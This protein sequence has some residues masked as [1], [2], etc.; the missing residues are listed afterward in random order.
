[1]K[2]IVSF[3]LITALGLVGCRGEELS[4]RR[5]KQTQETETTDETVSK[6]KAKTQTEESRTVAQDDIDPQM[7]QM[8]LRAAESPNQEKYAS[9]KVEKANVDSEPTDDQLA[10]LI[11]M[12][13][14]EF[15]ELANAE[16]TATET[17]VVPAEAAMALQGGWQKQPRKSGTGRFGT[18]WST[19]TASNQN[20][21]K[22]GTVSGVGP[23]GIGA[24]AGVV[25]NPS[26]GA[27]G[28]V[29]GWIP[30]YGVGIAVGGISVNG[31]AGG[32]YCGISIDGAGCGSF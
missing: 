32:G 13:R 5:T 29:V 27:A 10:T 31:Q 20:G 17:L 7:A 11:E 15:P 24:S 21:T 6:S 2:L 26:K 30:G 9:Y 19:Q 22:A 28:Y 3:G 12:A 8:A 16:F 1:M 18:Q 23:N 25:A 14:K 4:D